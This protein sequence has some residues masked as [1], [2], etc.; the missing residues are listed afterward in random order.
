MLVYKI[1][2]TVNGRI[3]IGVTTRSIDARFKAHVYRRNSKTAL[4]RAIKKHGR[5]VFRI[6]VIETCKTC[7]QMYDREVFWIAHFRSNDPAVGYN[8]T[9]GGDV[10]PIFYGKD[11]HNYGLPNPRAS[12]RNKL[13]KGKSLIEL[14]GETKALEITEKMRQSSLGRKHSTDS[15][16][17]MSA[18]RKAAWDSGKLDGIGSKIS[19]AKKGVPTK[20]RPIICLNNGVTYPSVTQAARELGVSE[21]NAWTVASGKYKSTK[22]FKFEFA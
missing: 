8:L 9:A 13:M 11:H 5:E 7:E 19:A 14:Y 1:T 15:L 12:A 6:E 18:A 17:K 21:G 16:L 2:N 20:G 10:G 3:Y 22:G 4:A